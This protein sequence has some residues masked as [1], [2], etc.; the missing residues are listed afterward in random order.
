M[1]NK[2][3]LFLAFPEAAE[4]IDYDLYCYALLFKGEYKDLIGLWNKAPKQ[5]KGKDVKSLLELARFVKSEIVAN[6]IDY[7]A[8][9]DFHKCYAASYLLSYLPKNEVKKI[10]NDSKLITQLIKAVENI[11]DFWRVKLLPLLSFPEELDAGTF[12][13]NFSQIKNIPCMFEETK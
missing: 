4:I 5:D 13:S 9:S 12:I 3:Q 1:S 2:I 8:I 10:F 6:N 7:S 11:K